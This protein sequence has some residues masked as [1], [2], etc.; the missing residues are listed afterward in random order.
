M[1]IESS[2][3]GSTE[4]PASA[5]KR[6]H[7]NVLELGPRKCL[8]VGLFMDPIFSSVMMLFRTT[9]DPLVHH[10]HHFGRVMHAFCNVQ[11]LMTNGIARLGK[12]EDGGLESLT[13]Q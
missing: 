12:D 11:T 8:Y 6:P 9:Q 1:P 10:G 13:A 7:V 2:D 3:R 5:N 4:S